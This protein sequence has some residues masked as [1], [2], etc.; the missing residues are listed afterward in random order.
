MKVLISKFDITDMVIN[1][2]KFEDENQIKLPK[3][4]KNF[5]ICYNGGITP[6]TKFRINN[7]SSDVVSFY[8]LG[9]ADKDYNFNQFNEMNM[10]RDYISV[11]ML[12]IAY[13]DFGDKIALSIID[14][15]FG[16]VF[17]YYHDIPNK[18]IKLTD[19]F[20]EFIKLCKS[21]KLGQIPSVEERMKMMIENG[22]G[23]KINEYSI[24]GW[25]AELDEY[26]NI[27]Q[28]KVII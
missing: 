18:F 10:L 19:N 24:K 7:I 12:P 3:D 9:N 25:Q 6:E 11:G 8:G 1:I 20:Q 5:L 26:S 17:Y 2:K 21:K 15:T 28:E 13:N 23:D 27:H 16:E 14:E 22:L 4:Y